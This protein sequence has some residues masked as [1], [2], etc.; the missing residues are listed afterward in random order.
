[1]NS[2]DTNVIPTIWFGMTSITKMA[3]NEKKKPYSKIPFYVKEKHF[4]ESQLYFW[5][6][7]LFPFN[8]F[9]LNNK[10][11]KVASFHFCVNGENK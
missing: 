1:M 7:T 6:Q 10:E 11:A 9:W 5:I 3:S 4:Y 2:K 8:N